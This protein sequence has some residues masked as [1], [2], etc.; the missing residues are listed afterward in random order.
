MD[1]YSCKHRGTVPGSVHSSCRHS[2]TKAFSDDPIMAIM[3]MLARGS[4]GTEFAEANGVK[5]N[6]TGV[7]NGWA[8]WPLNF[9]PIWIDECP[10]FEEKPHESNG[11]NIS[12]PTIYD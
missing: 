8:N 9:D 4:I 7:R 12:K 2:S 10:L 11:R 6:S 3:A 5:L 1:C